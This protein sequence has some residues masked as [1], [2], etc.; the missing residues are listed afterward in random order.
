M[1][2]LQHNLD[3]ALAAIG[4]RTPASTFRNIICPTTR[5]SH[6]RVVK[7]SEL[8]KILILRGASPTP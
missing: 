5:P 3:L 2:K 1:L 8:L 6:L 7:P 4:A